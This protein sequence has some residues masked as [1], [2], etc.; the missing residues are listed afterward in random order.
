MNQQHLAFVVIGILGLSQAPAADPSPESPAARIT[1]AAAD[2]GSALWRYTTSK[3]PQ[4]WETKNFD[5]SAWQEG[6][7]GFGAEVADARIGTPWSS[8]EI[9]LRRRFNRQ[10]GKLEKELLRIWHAGDAEVYIND[11][12]IASVKG[13]SPGFV[14]LPQETALPIQDGYDNFIAVHSVAKGA[15]R[16]IDLGILDLLPSTADAELEPRNAEDVV[17]L[18]KPLFDYP[19]RDMGV[20]LGHDGAYYMTAT[21]GSPDC[22]I[23]NDGSI[24]VWRS[25]DLKNWESLG[26]VWSFKEAPPWLKQMLEK[27]PAALWAPELHYVKG[28]YYIVYCTNQHVIGLLRSTTGKAQGPY[29]NVT[30]DAPLTSR[31][32]PSLFQDDDGTVYLLYQNRFIARMKDDM[33]G[34]AE[35]PREIRTTTGHGIGFEGVS[36]FKANGRYYLSCAENVATYGYSSVVATSENIY[37]PYGEPYVAL[38][39]AGHNNYMKDKDG[40]WWASM[41]GFDGR[42]PFY[43]RP[44]LFRVTFDEQGR[45]LP[46][47]TQ[48][49]RLATRHVLIPIADQGSPWRYTASAPGEGWMKPAFDDKG[50]S[51]GRGGFGSAN[52]KHELVKVKTEWTGPEIWLR[53]QFQ[54]PAADQPVPIFTCYSEGKCTGEVYINGVLAA[55]MKNGGKFRVGL[56]EEARRALEPGP[57]VL[58]LRI[59]SE[60][61]VRGFEAG[62]YLWD[63]PKPL[64]KSR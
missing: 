31:I 4:G 5:D 38:P 3:P 24:P 18:Q 17:R 19:V 53:Q 27:R 64:P 39:H 14:L 20:Q 23:S 6:A 10:G 21:A 8:D 32:D 34:L 37:G 54:M 13:S 51:S 47:G 7:A 30:Q 11:R 46:L 2:Q 50:W 63:I 9:W 55:E 62:L 58:S 52:L 57:N 33:S 43:E 45:V 28:N 29:E 44:G 15:A 48:D 60:K 36:M 16:F 49:R 22:W 56:A 12:K 41:F 26:K 40:N 25:V 35:E 61:P 42:S 59:Q 1:L